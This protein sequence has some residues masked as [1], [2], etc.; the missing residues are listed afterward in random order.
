MN[1]V[2]DDASGEWVKKWGYGGK[3]HRERDGSGRHD[4]GGQ[5]EWLVELDD[6]MVEK[7]DNLKEGEGVRGIGRR[8][9]MERM[10]RQG[11]KERKNEGRK[12]GG[13]GKGKGD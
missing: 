6:K 12:G 10:R 3:G 8:E 9:K 1:A 11:R 2:Y 13:G 5:G 7:E 4:R